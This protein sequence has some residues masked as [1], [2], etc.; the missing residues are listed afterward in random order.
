MGCGFQDGGVALVG[1]YDAVELFEV[2]GFGDGDAEFL[3]FDGAGIADGVADGFGFAVV[4]AEAVIDVNGRRQFVHNITRGKLDFK[5]VGVMAGTFKLDRIFSGF[6]GF[7]ESTGVRTDD[8][9]ANEQKV[10][11][12]LS[13]VESDERTIRYYKPRVVVLGF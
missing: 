6:L 5:V 2:V 7:E 3:D 1:G 8:A 10:A 12:G 11:G 13:V 9:R 4:A